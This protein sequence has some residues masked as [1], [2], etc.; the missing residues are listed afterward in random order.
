MTPARVDSDTFLHLV[1]CLPAPENYPH[2]ICS[3]EF[4]GD[5]YL[6][7]FSILTNRKIAASRVDGIEDQNGRK[8][9]GQH[10]TESD[11]FVKCDNIGSYIVQLV[12][13]MLLLQYKMNSKNWSFMS[14][15]LEWDCHELEDKEVDGG[16]DCR[17]APEKK[18][19]A[20]EENIRKATTPPHPQTLTAL[21]TWWQRSQDYE[22]SCAL[23]ARQQSPQSQW[24]S[25]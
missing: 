6:V 21:Q 25:K 1:H 7:F 5:T 8:G 24:W 14:H 10:S 15:L 9:P 22:S 17:K 2:H 3:Q 13:S 12:L 18:A 4:S 20:R 19:K 23:A 11:L 16:S